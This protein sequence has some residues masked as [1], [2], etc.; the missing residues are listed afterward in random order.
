[1]K[2][3]LVCL[4]VGV[5]F[6]FAGCSGRKPVIAVIDSQGDLLDGAFK[7]QVLHGLDP[8]EERAEI[9]R[10]SDSSMSFSKALRK[11]INTRKPD[12][13]WG[14]DSNSAKVFQ[15]E[16]ASSPGVNFIVMDVL[17]EEPASNLTG[18]SFRSWE[19]SFLAGYL[20]AKTSRTGCV[21]FIGGEEITAVKQF[22]YG[23][24][25]GALYAG[26]LDKKEITLEVAY[27]S[28][29]LS[30]ENGR[31]TAEELYGKGCDV[32]FQVCGQSGTGVIQEAIN[33]NHW[34]IGVN[35][36]QTAL[37]PDNMLTSV[38]KE[39]DIAVQ[40]I[41]ER[42]LAK[43]EIGG[44]NFVYGLENGGVSLA[45][46]NGNIPAEL[47]KELDELRQRIINQEL[48]PPSSQATYDSFVRV[49]NS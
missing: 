24:C 43:E 29:F 21:G 4:L 41:T 15:A 8:F 22:E 45:P 36:D 34:V 2:K 35:T 19:A 30:P 1:M 42:F 44:Q 10:A 9:F 28:T 40:D 7:E 25:A 20:A 5:L 16:A 49:L 27:T 33:Q 13:V 46:N 37:A 11:A 38:I 31:M 18:V 39:T 32:L 47:E 3:W 26:K 12:L 48:T 6:C 17:F 23:Y 14:V